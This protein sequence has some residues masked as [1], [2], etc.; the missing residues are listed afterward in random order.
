M[1]CTP[2]HFYDIVAGIRQDTIKNF[3][4]FFII[5]CFDKHFL[6]CLPYILRGP[7]IWTTNGSLRFN[8][9]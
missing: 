1:Y 5:I 3:Y 7:W 4:L 8:K 2:Q 6:I 9:M